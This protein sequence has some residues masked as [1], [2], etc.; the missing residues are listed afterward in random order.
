M[1]DLGIVRLWEGL[2]GPIVNPHA[3]GQRVLCDIRIM[4]THTIN[5]ELWGRGG[6]ARF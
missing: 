6:G 3:G 1:A 5:L 2:R 4:D